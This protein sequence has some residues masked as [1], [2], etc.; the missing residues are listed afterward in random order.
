[1]GRFFE[2]MPTVAHDLPSKLNN[3]ADPI[4]VYNEL[5]DKIKCRLKEN[6]AYYPS[7]KFW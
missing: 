5:T 4:Y 3:G 6:G 1:M 2:H 7:Q